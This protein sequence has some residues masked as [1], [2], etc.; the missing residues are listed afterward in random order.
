M[1]V[2]FLKKQG[3]DFLSWS[4]ASGEATASRV[5]LPGRMTERR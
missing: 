5:E 1:Q 3:N 4:V 2:T